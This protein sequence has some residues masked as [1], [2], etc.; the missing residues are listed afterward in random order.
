MVPDIS[1]LHVSWSIQQACSFYLRT[2]LE[3]FNFNELQALFV[4]MGAFLLWVE[5]LR[6]CMMLSQCA[7]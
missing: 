6:M 4:H 3:H 1:I 2:N 7:L 5:R